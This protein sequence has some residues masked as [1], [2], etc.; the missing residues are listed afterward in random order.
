MRVIAEGGV[1]IRTDDAVPVVGKAYVVISSHGHLSPNL[2]ENRTFEPASVR[3]ASRVT[4]PCVNG[5]TEERTL[6]A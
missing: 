3:A 2:E 6:R 4:C 5:N 1:G